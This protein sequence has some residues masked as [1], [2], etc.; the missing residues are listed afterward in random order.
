MF[1]LNKHSIVTIYI[2]IFYL[3][4]CLIIRIFTA[5]EGPINVSET[6][7]TP[8]VI[9]FEEINCSIILNSF[10]KNNKCTTMEGTL[11][12]NSKETLDLS[13]F[14]IWVLDG[15]NKATE[16]LA[17]YSQSSSPNTTL[18][19]NC[20]FPNKYTDTMPVKVFIQYLDFKNHGSYVKEAEVLIKK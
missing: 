9:S 7:E 14:K 13:N 12:N 2:S 18:D 3:F 16:N 17:Y 20:E 8:A 1:K 11:E 10:H 5:P 15:N 4:I 19:L 6:F